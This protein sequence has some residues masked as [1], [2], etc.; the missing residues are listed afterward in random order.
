[1]AE[2]SLIVSITTAIIASK[3][4]C[5]DSSSDAT[6]SY[7]YGYY[8]HTAPVFECLGGPPLHDA[9][10]V[11]HQLVSW[12]HDRVE[13]VPHGVALWRGDQLHHLQYIRTTR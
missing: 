2:G 8:P 7:H 12:Q 13:G 11:V 5:D 4:E 6:Q 1:M 10:L 3:G 9:E